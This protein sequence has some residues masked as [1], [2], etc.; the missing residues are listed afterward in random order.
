MLIFYLQRLYFRIYFCG[1]APVSLIYR[2]NIGEVETITQK[3]M[4]LGH[5]TNFPYTRTRITLYPGD[6]I[7]ICSD[8]LTEL[9]NEK[10]EMLETENLILLLQKV[11]TKSPKEI[12]N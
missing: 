2:Q 7:L 5:I 11:G 4:P 9:F 6:T 8:G 3:G 10:N 12:I 1:Y